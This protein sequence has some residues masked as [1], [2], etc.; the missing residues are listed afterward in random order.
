MVSRLPEVPRGRRV[1]LGRL[2]PNRMPR[3]QLEKELVAMARAFI[4][5]RPFLIGR[6]VV[7]YTASRAQQ[8]SP[9]DADNEREV[10][11][12]A[13]RVRVRVP[14]LKLRRPGRTFIPSAL[15]RHSMNE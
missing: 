14:L 10:R 15:R 6:L 4:S 7:A 13:P 3:P 5:L 9:R 2:H 8:V 1:H 11:G 12:R